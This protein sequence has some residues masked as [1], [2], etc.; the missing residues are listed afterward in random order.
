MVFAAR[1]ARCTSE[2]PKGPYV[3][4]EV[5]RNRSCTVISRRIGSSFNV[6]Y[7]NHFRVTLL[8][9]PAEIGEVFGRIERALA[10]HLDAPRQA[11]I[12]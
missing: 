6:R 10:R 4:P 2:S 11:A 7:R 3:R 5:C 8:P 9:E 1:C 12:A